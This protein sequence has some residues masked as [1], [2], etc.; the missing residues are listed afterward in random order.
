MKN[1]LKTLSVLLILISF[2]GFSQGESWRWYF[3]LTAG[4][5][6]PGAGAPVAM[7]NGMLMTMEGVATIS[8]AAGN[9]LFYTDGSTV[10]NKLH[11]VMTNGNGLMGNGSSTQSGVIIPKPGSP[12]NYYLF[13]CNVAG[14][15]Y[16]FSEIDMLASAGNGAVIAG[17]NNTMVNINNTE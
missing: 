1:I 12:N 7:T 9:L 3:G 15:G 17:N 13:T 6:F 10:W 11:A 16:R 2:Q 14:A 8:D 5:N 4:A